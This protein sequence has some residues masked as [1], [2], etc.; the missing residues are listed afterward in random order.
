MDINT[1][2]D[3]I[4]LGNWKQALLIGLI[5]AAFTLSKSK[6]FLAL[7]AKLTD[8]LLDI[9]MKSRVGNVPVGQVLSSS[10]LVHNTLF[11]SVDYWVSSV[12]PSMEFST[13]YRNIVFKK[14]LTLYLT[15]YKEVISD[16]VYTEGYVN[17]D[18]DEFEQSLR[19]LINKV[20][21]E[22]D[23]KMSSAKI[24]DV[25][26]NKMKAENEKILSLTLD[27]VGAVSRS[28]NQVDEKNIAKMQTFL[29]LINYLLQT[30]VDGS[31]GVCNSIN[32]QLSGL[33][34]DGE[35]EPTIKKPL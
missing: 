18:S 23:K 35:T 24:P 15:S 22:S 17:M 30:I 6:W 31:V 27:F 21:V 7:L 26:V 1:I 5:F 29:T 28:K 10:A 11:S 25:V 16:F 8:G 4:K 14:Y 3:L 9:L 13:S 19:G 2:I 33:S 32:G 12:V 20:V 34:M